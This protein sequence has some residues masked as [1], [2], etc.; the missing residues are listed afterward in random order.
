MMISL[1]ALGKI[2]SDKL[3][4]EWN[5]DA[6]SWSRG[7]VHSANLQ[8]AHAGQTH[9]LRISTIPKYSATCCKGNDRRGTRQSR[10]EANKEA[11]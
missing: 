1:T 2:S 5:S 4:E 7:I 11:K 8:T 3:A 9:I 10:A 6:F